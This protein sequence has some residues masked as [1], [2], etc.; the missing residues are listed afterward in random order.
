LVF[1]SPHIG[2]RR[3]DVSPGEQNRKCL[4]FSGGPG[5]ID[6]PSPM[7]RPMVYPPTTVSFSLLSSRP[8]S[9]YALDSCRVSGRSHNLPGIGRVDDGCCT[10]LSLRV[11]A[12]SRHEGVILSPPLRRHLDRGSPGRPAS[13]RGVHG[14]WR[15]LGGTRS[16]ARE[17]LHAQVLLNCQ[18]HR[19]RRPLVEIA[20]GREDKRGH[21]GQG[22]LTVQTQRDSLG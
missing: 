1:S 3:G 22:R 5:N 6:S 9:W 4:D 14:G 18:S 7:T 11:V 17:C 20:S 12:L 2:F 16:C 21:E 13:L 15:R 8:S 10:H 19:R